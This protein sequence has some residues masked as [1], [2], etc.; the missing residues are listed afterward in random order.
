MTE[1]KFDKRNFRKHN[2]KNKDLIRKS[3]DECGAGRSI[4]IDN[5][6]E[7]IA[8]NGVYEQA[9]V[10][11]IP[12]K[13]IETNGN[14][15]IAVKRTDLNT[16]DERRK[17]LAVMDNS[18]SDT[19]EFDFDLLNVD[20]EIP[21]LKDMGIDIPE[22]KEKKLKD[23]SDELTEEYEV[24]VEC[25]DEEEQEKIFTQLNEMGLKCRLLTL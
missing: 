9:K 3:L 21:E 13:I 23:I 2:D 4:L 24:V 17:R 7:I 14:E 19:S 25:S 5:E 8:G 11:N 15:L 18:T 22:I 10:L 1:I 6:N 16:Q 12:V 20:F